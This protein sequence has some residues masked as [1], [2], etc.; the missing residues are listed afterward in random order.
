MLR[1]Q[2]LLCVVLI[3]GVASVAP[4]SAQ[5]Q[6]ELSPAVNVHCSNTIFRAYN[7]SLEDAKQISDQE[8]EDLNNDLSEVCKP[9]E[10]WTTKDQL[11]R[12]L[13]LDGVLSERLLQSMKSD[14]QHVNE[15]T[16]LYAE[17]KA[18]RSE[19]QRLRDQLKKAGAHRAQ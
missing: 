4:T 8:L 18:L 17:V 1:L 6:A 3:V 2:G 12:A 14:T 5:P 11:Y 10:G 13:A 9:V 15:A 16:D 19:N 7:T